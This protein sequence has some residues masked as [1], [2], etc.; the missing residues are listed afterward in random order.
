[1]LDAGK[2]MKDWDREQSA[3]PKDLEYDED[4]DDVF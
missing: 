4:E 3:A 1:M 2:K